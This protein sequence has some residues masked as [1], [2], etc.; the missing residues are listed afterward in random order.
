MI[1][2]NN[3]G[4]GEAINLLTASIQ[5]HYE[6]LMVYVVVAL[7]L[8]GFKFSESYKKI[9]VK[10]SRIVIIGFFIFSLSNTIAMQENIDHYNTILLLL[11]TYSYDD[12]LID[13]KHIFSVFFFKDASRIL[14]F[15]MGITLIML[16]VIKK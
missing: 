15:Q 1:Q 7:G 5:L 12:Y 13:F 10:R 3:L 6:I 8:L 9:S 11:K 14:I 4:L 16:Y 2:D